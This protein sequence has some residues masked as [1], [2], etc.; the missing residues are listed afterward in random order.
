MHRMATYKRR[1]VYL[2]DEEWERISTIAHDHGLTVSAEIRGRITHDWRP[3]EPG[4][5]VQHGHVTERCCALFEPS[6]AK[7]FL[8]EAVR[9]IATPVPSGTTFV[10]RIGLEV[11]P[12]RKSQQAE[13]DAILRKI[14]KGE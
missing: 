6:A 7:P 10:E 1:I 14:N 12:T 11:E 9:T 8:A 2:S 5:C 4:Q 13:R 3:I